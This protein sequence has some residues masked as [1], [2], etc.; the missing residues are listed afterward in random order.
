V[1]YPVEI[2]QPIIGRPIAGGGDSRARAN[3]VLRFTK[4][5]GEK[6]KQLRLYATYIIANDTATV[7]GARVL[8][9]VVSKAKGMQASF[10]LENS[11]DLFTKTDVSRKVCV[12]IVSCEA[13]ELENSYLF[14]RTFISFS[15]SIPTR[16]SPWRGMA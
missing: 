15:S 9:M 4:I 16:A 1:V 3:P 14:I 5:K 12:H 2:P 10:E 8:T 6:K 11:V 13:R 7:N